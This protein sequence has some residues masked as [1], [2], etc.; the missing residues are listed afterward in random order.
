MESLYKL[1]SFWIISQAFFWS[2]HN[3]IIEINFRP[4]RILLF[5]ILATFGTLV[6]RKKIKLLPISHIE[7]YMFVFTLLAT[8]SLLTS[9]ANEDPTFGKN[10][11]LSNLFN[12]TYLPFTTF[13]IMKNMQYS[14]KGIKFLVT[15]LTLLGAYLAITGMFEHYSI[16]SLI[17]PK[18]IIDPSRGHHFGRTRGPFIDS[19]AMG[20]A[21]I[22]SF[23]FIILMISEHKGFRKSILFVLILLTLCS[24]YFTYT[25]GPWLGFAAALFVIIFF[26][27]NLRKPSLTIIVF[28]LLIATIGVGNKFSLWGDTLFSRRQNTI[29]DRAIS[30]SVQIQMGLANPFFGVGYG[31]FRSEWD[32]YV[33]KVEVSQDFGGFDESHNTYLGLFSETGTTGLF[34]YCMIL[35]SL[36]RMCF[37][38]YKKIEEVS[39]FEKSLTI[40]CMAAGAMYGLTGA[41]SDLR[42]IQ[43]Q[44]NLMFLFFGIIASLSA[45]QVKT[46]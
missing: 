16:D 34:F 33:S 3:K 11:W 43:Y 2:S 5:I 39:S 46:F 24:I 37:A 29:S 41:I 35:A 6:L 17:W 1:I 10:K 25:R 38:T 42:W 4:D 45:K 7:V 23:L 12:I 44:N 9:G 32:N 21:L 40:M 19:V 14:R 31:N 20:R 22:F 36:M 30:Y 15:S 26:R 27:S 28:I 18:A 8:I 13:F